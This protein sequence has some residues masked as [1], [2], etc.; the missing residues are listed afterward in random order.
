MS[1]SS[2]HEGRSSAGRAIRIEAPPFQNWSCHGCTSCC[3]GRL[4]IQLSAADNERI[5]AQG[6]T[7]A[8][9]INP[10]TMIIEERGQLRL[11]HQ[12]DGACVFLDGAGRCR[13]HGRFGEAAKPLACR[14]Y[15]LAIHPAGDKLVVSLRFSCP[16]AAAST[17]AALSEQLPSIRRLADEV[18]PPGYEPGPPP[19]VLRGPGL[20]WPDFLRYVSYLDKTMAVPSSPVLQNLLRALHWLKA[21]EKAQ[22]D[23]LT[24]PDA[25][26][27]LGALVKSAGEKLPSLTRTVPSP[28]R[29]GKLFFRLLVIEHA[30]TVTVRDMLSPGRYRGKMLWALLRFATGRGNVPALSRELKSVPFAELEKPF[31]PIPQDAEAMLTRFIRVKIQGLHFCGK[32]YYGEPLIEGFYSLA[33]LLPIILWIARWLALAEGRSGLSAG[34]IARAIAI[35]DHN[36]GYAP[37][38]GAFGSRWRVRL[39]A[40]RDD[41]SRLCWSCSR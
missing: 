16:S 7:E 18:V 2:R 23:Q 17:G 1:R 26:E 5:Q 36:H 20:D 13:I 10:E 34:E 4:L 37:N 24:G 9:G 33:L 25:D 11:G 27:V 28:S 14:L 21:V 35:A 29:F 3:R 30:R 31:G 12:A 8:D 41:I 38:L 39:L 40:H 19:P 22:F 15:P 6:W 32:A